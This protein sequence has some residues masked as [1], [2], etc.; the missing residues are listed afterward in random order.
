VEFVYLAIKAFGSLTAVMVTSL[1]KAF[2]VCLSFI[3]FSNKVFTFWH[4]ISI[5]V[6]SLG[7]GMNVYAKQKP[8]AE[9]AAK[10]LEPPDSAPF[11]RVN[12]RIDPPVREVSV[13]P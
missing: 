6:I 5:S 9:M 11:L 4:A 8:K 1:R 12:D 10:D 3:I 7:I 2:T 13:G